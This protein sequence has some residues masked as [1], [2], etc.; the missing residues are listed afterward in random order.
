MQRGD[1]FA[2]ITPIILFGVVGTFVAFF[3]FSFMTILVNRN[4]TLW[5]YKHNSDT[6]MY[7]QIEMNLT[8]AECLLF[9]SLMCSSDVV[10]AISLISYNE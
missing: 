7:D 6:G 5:Q 10:A 8:D 4:M 1:F 9:C 3:S 2:N